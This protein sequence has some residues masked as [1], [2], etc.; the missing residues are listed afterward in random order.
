M[1]EAPSSAQLAVRPPAEDGAYVLRKLASDL[2]LSADG[3]AEVRITCVEVWSM[4]YQFTYSIQTPWLSNS[5]LIAQVA[6]Q[7]PRWQPLCRYLRCRDHSLRHTS[8]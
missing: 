6:D 4:Y 7:V 2:P 5:Y 3:D 8:S 1:A